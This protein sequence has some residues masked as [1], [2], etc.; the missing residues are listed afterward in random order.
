M[1]NTPLPADPVYR[2]H[3]RSCGFLERLLDCQAPLETPSGWWVAEFRQ[4][5]GGVLAGRQHPEEREDLQVA[6]QVAGD[7]P[8]RR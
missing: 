5:E 6:S 1:T 2:S 4:E 7:P 3:E 8:G